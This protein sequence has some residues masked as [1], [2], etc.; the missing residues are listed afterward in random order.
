M[1]DHRT[2]HTYAIDWLVHRGSL[3]ALQEMLGQADLSTTA[4]YTKVTQDLVD[5]EAEAVSK[6]RKGAGNRAL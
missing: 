1:S 6:R 2:R 5:R 4:I 3:A